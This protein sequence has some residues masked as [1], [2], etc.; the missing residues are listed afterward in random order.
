L[1]F[2]YSHN[3]HRSAQAFMWQRTLDLA[4]RL[5][6]LLKDEEFD[7]STGESLWDR[8]LIY[9]ATDFG[10]SRNRVAGSDLFGSG[11]HLN[12]GNLIISPLANGNSVLGGVDRDTGLTYGFD[13]Q[14]GAPDPDRTMGE[15]DIYAGIL[16]ALQVT[17]TGSGLPDMPAM[18][19]AG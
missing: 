3:D 14:T 12:N 9:V 18:R 7:A 8:T 1:A 16:Q 5:I 13:P 6:D 10:R 19:R 15:A 4:D 2:D 11:H 17:T